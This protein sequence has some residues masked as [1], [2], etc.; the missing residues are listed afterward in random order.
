MAKSFSAKFYLS[1]AWIECRNG[2]IQSI[3]GLCERCLMQGKYEPGYIVHH[4]VYLT[5]RNINNPDVS[6]NWD[7]LEYVCKQCHLAEHMTK[8]A[9]TQ[10][11]LAFDDNGDL[12]VRG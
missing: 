9:S 6:L 2:Y 8:Y 7:N 4:K 10:D 1:K 5:P 12:I 3:H 11:G